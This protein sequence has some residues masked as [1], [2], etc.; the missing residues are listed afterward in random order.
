MVSN[1]FSK[2]INKIIDLVENNDHNMKQTNV[3]IHLRK[4]IY[5]YISETVTNGDT[6]SIQNLSRY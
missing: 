3:Q 6:N 1:K 4:T 2:L 5:Y